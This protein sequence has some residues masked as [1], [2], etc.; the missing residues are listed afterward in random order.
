[1]ENHVNGKRRV[2]MVLLV[3]IALMGW[4]FGPLEGP[5][6]DGLRTPTAE[7]QEH[8]PI[9]AGRSVA[10]FAHG[11]KWMCGGRFDGR[12]KYLEP[13]CIETL[14]SYDGAYWLNGRYYMPAIRLKKHTFLG[15]YIRFGYGANSWK[16]SIVRF[17]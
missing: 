7:A 17:K 8:Q 10:G 12:G 16:D 14:V 3:F 2:G 13:Y 9:T 11:A 5:C 6:I 4:T 1:M 15:W